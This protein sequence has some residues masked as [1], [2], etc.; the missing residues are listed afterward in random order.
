MPGMR[1]LALGVGN[2][3][4]ELYYSTSMALEAEGKRLLIDCPHPI[5]KIVR[6]ASLSAGVP[7]SLEQIDTVVLTHLHA[8]HCSGLEGFIYYHRFAHKK[9]ARVAADAEVSARL[10][11]GHLAAAMEWSDE[12]PGVA[13]VRRRP[14]DFYELRPLNE[15]G[16]TQLGPF[17][18][19][20]RRTI[21]SIPTTALL[22]RGGGRCLGYSADTAFDPALIDWLAEADLI[23][24]ET[25]PEGPHTPYEKL[26]ALPAEVRAKMRLVHYPDDFHQAASSIELMRQGRI[27]RVEPR[28]QVN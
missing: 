1:V 7:V 22:I 14:E 26:A 4:S 15:T 5:R 8:D 18:V 19:R 24:H 2:A 9:R 3:F 25:G 12:G 16:E 28:Q 13:A 27:Y 20:C 6:E 23:V 11:P 21:H 17:R 10:W